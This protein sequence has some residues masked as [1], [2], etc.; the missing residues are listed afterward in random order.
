MVAEVNFG[1]KVERGL[2][3]PGR[4][5]LVSLRPSKIFVPDLYST[6]NDI[7][8]E[9]HRHVINIS[10][11]CVV[12]SVHHSEFCI[13]HTPVLQSVLEPGS[14]F[15]SVLSLPCVLFVTTYRPT[16]NF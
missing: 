12:C 1:W 7:V 2:T 4:S 16:A 6:S 8:M 13:G 11:S 3:D 5:N 14:N 10:L 9:Y 15:G